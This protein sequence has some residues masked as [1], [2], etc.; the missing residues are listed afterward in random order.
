MGFVEAFKALVSYVYAQVA[1]NANKALTF[2]D[3][4][5]AKFGDRLYQA[6]FKTY[7]EKVWGI[8]CNQIGADWASQRIKGLDF[9]E[10]IKNSLGLKKNTVKTL[11]SEFDFPTLGAGMMY[12][13]M[14][15]I[16]VEKGMDLRL[17]CNIE[18]IVREGNK[19]KHIEAVD[20]EGNRI[21]IEAESY[22]STIPMT[23]L[24]KMT[25]PAFDNIILDANDALYYR[26]HITVNLLVD[27][28]D[29]FPDQWIYVHSPDVQLA[30]LANFNNFNRK[31]VNREGASAICVEYFVF[32]SDPIW[33]QSDEELIKLAVEEGNYMKLIPRGRVINGWVIRETECY[34]TYYIGYQEPFNSTKSGL[35]SLENCVPAGRGG[36]YKYNNMDHS[37]FTGILAAR[38]LLKGEVSRELI[39]RVNIDTEY[40]ESAERT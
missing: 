14:A 35:D 39:W 11:V 18:K 29:L 8:P 13:R 31:M 4:V 32:K 1:F 21:K 38:H 3:W 15:E 7:T 5:K 30:R 17:N 37:I 12:E 36:M 20:D 34:P 25:E 9:S 33:K 2:E 16:L 24:I 6:F 22:V 23:H 10:V 28:N 19:V 26:D 40:H 27:Q